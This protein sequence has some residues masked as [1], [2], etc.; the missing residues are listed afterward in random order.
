MLRSWKQYGIAASVN[1]RQR[2]KQCP[3]RLF[4]RAETLTFIDDGILEAALSNESA[5]SVHG[6]LRAASATSLMAYLALFIPRLASS[7][8][9]ASCALFNKSAAACKLSPTWSHEAP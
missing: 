4:E 8:V 5:A 6:Q 3:D 7:K 1:V 9:F 2:F